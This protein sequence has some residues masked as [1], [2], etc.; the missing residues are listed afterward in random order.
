MK[1]I[2]IL[3]IFIVITMIALMAPGIKAKEK[4][5]P[6]ELQKIEFKK[7]VHLEVGITTDPVYN[8]CYYI[9]YL[10]RPNRPGQFVD[11]KSTF[12]NAWLILRGF[13]EGDGGRVTF[14]GP[15]NLVFRLWTYDPETMT[16]TCRH[17]EILGPERAWFRTFVED[18][19]NSVLERGERKR[20]HVQEAVKLTPIIKKTIM[21]F[22]E[23]VN[24]LEADFKFPSQSDKS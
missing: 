18:K 20:L 12:L 22:S 5:V 14:V 24:N 8:G 11:K 3:S 19:D 10:E 13:R 15:L 21:E 2:K 7:T 9:K 16:K 17:W 1:T 4:A 6:S 23:R